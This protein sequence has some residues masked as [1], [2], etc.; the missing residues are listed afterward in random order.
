MELKKSKIKYC[1]YCG[2]STKIEYIESD[3]QERIVCS[4]CGL[5]N[6]INPRPTAS[7]LILNDKNEILLT[8]RGQEP[9]LG[10]WDIPG[11]FLEYGEHPE[12]ALNREMNE[13]LNAD[14]HIDLLLGIHMDIYG[15]DADIST[16]NIFYICR[17]ESDHLRAGS[18][19]AD[20]SWF[21]L[22]NLPEI[23]A[24]DCSQHA[25]SDL[26]KWKNQN[27]NK[28]EEL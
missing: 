20:F 15:T 13:E 6:Y 19:V 3:N 1:N 25:L 22:D 26:K 8:K 5:I 10:F 4:R 17:L 21:N 28:K 16:L 24:F 18:D 2:S 7:A 11:G 12:K 27:H 23:I 14:V 9:Y